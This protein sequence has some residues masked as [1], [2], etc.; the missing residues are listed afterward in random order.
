MS[1]RAPLNPVK[2]RKRQRI[3][4]NGSYVRRNGSWGSYTRRT[5]SVTRKLDYLDAVWLQREQTGSL[6]FFRVLTYMP[7][8]TYICSFM[9]GKT[10]AEM[11]YEE[12]LFSRCPYP[13]VS[14]D[15]SLYHD[16]EEHFIRKFDFDIFLRWTQTN[17]CEWISFNVQQ[18]LRHRRLSMLQLQQLSYKY[19]MVYIKQLMST[20]EYED[21]IIEIMS[22]F[23]YLMQ[24]E[25]TGDSM[26]S[27]AVYWGHVRLLEYMISQKCIFTTSLQHIYSDAVH[28]YRRDYRVFDVLYP[29]LG[30]VPAD[31]WHSCCKRLCPDCLILAAAKERARKQK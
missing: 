28:G 2:P 8:L 11:N 24:T 17:L 14:S 21:D 16:V 12:I 19:Q 10:Y 13:I 3:H 4:M 27:W 23:P 1:K 5:R 22:L 7:L 20:H 9:P 18:V 6:A 29:V 15:A 25:F 31:D 26:A 30:D